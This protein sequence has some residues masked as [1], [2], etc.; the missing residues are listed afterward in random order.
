MQSDFAIQVSHIKKWYDGKPKPLTIFDDVT[1][2]IRKEECLAIM[3][4][5]GSGKTTLLNLIAGFDQ[6]QHGEIYVDGIDITKLSDEALARLRAEKIGVVFQL[7]NLMQNLTVY[8]NV[9]LPLILSNWDKEKRRKRVTE[10]LERALISHYA[11]RKLKTLSVGE[12]QLVALARALIKDP[13]ILL[14]DEPLEYLDPLTTDML[15]ALLRGEIMREKT[16]IITTHKR[17]IANIAESVIHLKKRI[18]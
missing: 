9:E 11:D 8:E 18:P 12:S 7:H 6:P 13:G 2:N 4:P 3:G 5:T 16:L 15:I 14:L 10:I 17:K 1:F